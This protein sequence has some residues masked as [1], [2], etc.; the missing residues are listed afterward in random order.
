MLR[1]V[2]CLCA[3]PAARGAVAASASEGGASEAAAVVLRVP[4]DG[5]GFASALELR[6]GD[7]PCAIVSAFCGPSESCVAELGA[8]VQGAVHARWHT[9]NHSLAPLGAAHFCGCDAAC[10]FGLRAEAPQSALGAELFGLLERVIKARDSKS[11]L[12]ATYNARFTALPL[13]ERLAHHFAVAR[14]MPT[15]AWALDGLS[16]VLRVDGRAYEADAVASYGVRH[17][18]WQSEMQRPN[19]FVPGLSTSAWWRPGALAETR[20]LTDAFAQIARRELVQELVRG[21]RAPCVAPQ[22]EGIDFPL[23][24]RSRASDDKGWEEI[25]LFKHGALAPCASRFPETVASLAALGHFFNAKFSILHPQ[26]R[27][28]PHCGPTNARLRAHVTIAAARGATIRV[29]NSPPRE[30]REDEVFIFDDSFEHE[31]VHAGDQPRVVLILDFWHPQLPI[32]ARIY[33]KYGAG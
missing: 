28:L 2:V 23:G 12:L 29:G 21:G 5:G 17:G 14:L 18:L 1:L 32:E 24:G 22:A 11:P 8:H 10:D 27:I 13:E 15:N 33:A 26:T 19:T 30:W 25:V 9:L 4:V 7:E 3:L 31:V 16:T 6:A 20:A